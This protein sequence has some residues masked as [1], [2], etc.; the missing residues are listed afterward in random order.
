MQ[1]RIKILESRILFPYK[2]LSYIRD[3][4]AFVIDSPEEV[5]LRGRVDLLYIPE[6]DITIPVSRI[7]KIEVNLYKESISSSFG[8]STHTI[9]VILQY[10][11]YLHET[12]EVHYNRSIPIEPQTPNIVPDIVEE[13]KRFINSLFYINS[14]RG[15][16]I[17][18]EKLNFYGKS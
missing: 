5:M 7:K 6:D 16:N 12:Q 2:K 10:N 11:T 8:R 3:R 14:E 1:D 15:K 17:L 9:K 13:A 18:K 4:T